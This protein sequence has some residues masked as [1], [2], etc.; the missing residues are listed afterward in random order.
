MNKHEKLNLLRLNLEKLGNIA[1]AYSGG[2][3]STF[4]LK[5]AHD[6]LKER[7]LAVTAHA[8]IHARRE[9]EEALDFVSKLGARHVVIAPDILKIE[10]FI[11]NPENKCYICKRSVFAEIIEVARK[12][13]I[14]HVADGS[15][16]DDLNDYR[17][18]LLA[19]QELAVISP[20]KEVGM[21]KE[22]IRELS[23]EMNL[24]TWDKPPF[25]CLA[26]RIPYG[27]RITSEKLEMVDRAEQFLVD[28]GFPQ[29]RVRHHGDTARIE[30][31]SP[32]R[33]KFFDEDFMDR[34]YKRLKEIGFTYVALDLKGYRTGSL[35]EAMLKSSS[36]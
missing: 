10:E 14:N 25:A 9:F 27:Q 13:G 32:E 34:V 21:T 6:E 23:R 35:N 36:G 4:L 7:V 19:L 33:K 22:D 3:D 5:V 2:V 24:P 16:I 15:N 31:P 8:P 29:V 30:V 11:A 26:S 18:G 20:L 1:I 28:S 17:P 12:N